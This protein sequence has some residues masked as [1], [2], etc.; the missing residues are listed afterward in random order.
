M[1]VPLRFFSSA[2]A[3]L[4]L[5]AAAWA[6]PPPTPPP[7]APTELELQIEREFREAQSDPRAR[8]ATPALDALLPRL[9][10]TR[11][12]LGNGL[13]VVLAPHAS[14]HQAAVVVTYRVG[15]GDLPP[16]HAG[17]PHLAEHL[18][19]RATRHAPQGLLLETESAD[20]TFF[21]GFTGPDRTIYVAVVPEGSV[22]RMLW[23]ESER[24]AFALDGVTEAALRHERQVVVNEYRQRLA[25]SSDGDASLAIAR[26]LYPENHLRRVP[27]ARPEGIA[28][29][30]L[31]DVRGFLASRYVPANARLLV[32]GRFDVA[33]VRGWVERYFGTVA[34][35]PA[36]PRPRLRGPGT[37]SGERILRYRLPAAYDVVRV[38]WPTPAL[39]APGDAELDVLSDLLAEPETGLLTRALAERGLAV[40]VRAA[41]V[42]HD[43]GSE[44]EVEVVVSPGHTAEQAL[45]VIDRTL[46]LARRQAPPA[47]AV[48][49]ASRRFCR[50]VVE[51]SGALLDWSMSLAES[52][53]APSAE[54]FT[55]ELARYRA[56]R[57]D[58]VRRAFEQLLP[59][60]R[61][62]VVLIERSPSAPL[63][64]VVES[65]RSR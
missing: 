65:V 30:T 61:R 40:S 5:G 37:L 59:L 16:E 4:C 53:D 55:R 34:R 43:D 38:V 18:S 63:G 12:Q 21:N 2:T 58:D 28:A 60:S 45:D 14:G 51:R 33:A 24:M 10:V 35:A 54:H 49:A 17:L 46:S 41:Q 50:A 9:T 52:A 19:Y 26:E 15:S 42:S 62:L 36:P 8:V 48:E 23:V 64:G 1:G 29:L 20:A 7:R 39:R 44:F 31:D 6:D 57:P 3:L 32:A 11:Y 27:Y 22:E 13:E 47:D 25:A 56:V